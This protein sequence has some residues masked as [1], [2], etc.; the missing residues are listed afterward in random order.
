[1][2]DVGCWQ[3]LRASERARRGKE[4]GERGE[5]VRRAHRASGG[6]RIPPSLPPVSC[7]RLFP[8]GVAATLLAVDRSDRLR[9]KALSLAQAEPLRG[10]APR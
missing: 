1:M 10:A 3:S 4:S 5:S 6:R 2:C 9:R 7:P 8:P